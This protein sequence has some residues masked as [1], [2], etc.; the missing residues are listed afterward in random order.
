MNIIRFFVRQ[1]LL[2]V[3]LAVTILGAGIWA[4]K[5]LPVDAFPDVSNIQV[6]VLTKAPGLSTSEVERQISYPIELAMAGLP[7]V[8]EVRSLSKNGLSQVRADERNRGNPDRG[9]SDVLFEAKQQE[10]SEEELPSHPLDAV[11]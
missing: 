3:L 6:M 9:P 4:W 7:L 10:T 1:R 5:N 8:T 11:E 2:S